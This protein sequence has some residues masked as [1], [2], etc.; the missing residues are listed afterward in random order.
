MTFMVNDEKAAELNARLLPSE[1][2]EMCWMETFQAAMYCAVATGRYDLDWHSLLLENRRAQR[3]PDMEDMI[4]N[5]E[6]QSSRGNARRLGK[7]D[8][9]AY[10]GRIFYRRS[11]I[12][13]WLDCVT[14]KLPPPPPT[15]H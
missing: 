7:L 9:T 8:T 10:R 13:S 3:D 1:V 14:H 12:D 2:H 6:I 4:G 15:L 11:R 5:E